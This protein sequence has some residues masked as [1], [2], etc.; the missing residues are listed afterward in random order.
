[1]ACRFELADLLSRE[2]ERLNQASQSLTPRLCLPSFEALDAAN[3]KATARGQH[4][5]SQTSEKPLLLEQLA[6]TRRVVLGHASLS[7][8][9][10][11]RVFSRRTPKSRLKLR[12]RVVT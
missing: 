12:I 8:L 4:L 3:P 10:V 1:M 6:E 11:V 7:R 2:L 5:L 9:S